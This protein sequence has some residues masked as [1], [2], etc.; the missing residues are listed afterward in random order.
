[1]DIL[2]LMIVLIKMCMAG[3]AAFVAYGMLK[4]HR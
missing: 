1:M 3:V 2:S 4:E